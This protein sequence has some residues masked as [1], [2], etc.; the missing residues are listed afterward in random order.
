MAENLNEFIPTRQSLLSR[1]KN[2]DDQESWKD[3]FQTYWKLIYNV[4]V[5]AGLS[6]ADAQDVVQETVLAVAKQ[7]PTFEYRAEGG[8]FKAWLLQITRRTIGHRLRKR[9]PVE[10]GPA[11][12]PDDSTRTPTAERIPD[13]AS[14]NLDAVWE[15]EW[16]KNLVDAA[17]ES[18][19]RK[20]K[21][22][23]YQMFDTYVVKEWPVKRVC[24]TLHVSA[25]QVYLAKFRVSALI[26]KEMKKL[27][28]KMS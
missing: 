21:P 23:Q 25:A 24:R 2:W 27:E 4:A 8:S 5:K 10:A 15:Q 14:L 3:F 7:M 19:K 28:T 9:T 16:Q 6:D 20:V 18:V 12:A 11:R 22:R 17:M 13:P 26:R 1:L